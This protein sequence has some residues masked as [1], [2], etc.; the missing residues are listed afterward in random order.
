MVWLVILTMVVH[1]L[2]TNATSVSKITLSENRLTMVF[3]STMADIA[4]VAL[5]YATGWFLAS[6]FYA[7][8]TLPPYTGS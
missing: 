5:L 4:M 3:A 1:G 8:T 2:M 7:A 6:A